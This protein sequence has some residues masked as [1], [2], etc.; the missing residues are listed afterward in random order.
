[1]CAHTYL[2]FIFLLLVIEVEFFR[3]DLALVT[4]KGIVLSI[5]IFTDKRT[6]PAII[7]HVKP[8]L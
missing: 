2:I 8:F 1:M 7:I 4:L 6:N 3:K 5:C